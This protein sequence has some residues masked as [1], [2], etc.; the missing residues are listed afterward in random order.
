LFGVVVSFCVVVLDFVC[1]FYA[2]NPLTSDRT[3]RRAERVVSQATVLIDHHNIIKQINS[4]HKA[5]S[6]THKQQHPFTFHPSHQTM[7]AITSF[8]LLLCL[9]S[10]ASAFSLPN[11][12]ASSSDIAIVGCG[13][14]G[15]SLCK[16]LLSSPGF[17]FKTG[18]S[19]AVSKSSRVY[20]SLDKI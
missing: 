16:Q 10:P 2:K 6:T 9:L 3:A 11:N 19:S 4:K 13:V 5:Q 15:T 1:I 20:D 14:L 7:A 8:F 12:F 18:E 17:E